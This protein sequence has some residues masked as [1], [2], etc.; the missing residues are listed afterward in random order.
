MGR[1]VGKGKRNAGKE[2]QI[3]VRVDADDD[4]SSDGGLTHFVECLVL[5]FLICD[6]F[7]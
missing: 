2:G 5:S 3:R 6:V 4:D 7:A 1:R